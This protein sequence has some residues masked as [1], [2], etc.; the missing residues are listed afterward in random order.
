VRLSYL[1]IVGF[2]RLAFLL[3]SPEAGKNKLSSP[4][5]EG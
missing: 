1:K 3:H 4:P 5:R 2:L